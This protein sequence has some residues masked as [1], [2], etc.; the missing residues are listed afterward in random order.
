MKK[1]LIGAAIGAGL[2]ACS[3]LSASAAV[4]CSDNVC[5]H[6]TETY[7]YPPTARVTIHEDTWR[8]GPDIKFREHKGRGYWAG[9]VWTDF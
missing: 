9:D 6:T 3:A 7:E 2:L 4:V 8:A 1:I 5:W